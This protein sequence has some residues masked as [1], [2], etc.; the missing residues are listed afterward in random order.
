MNTH[1][2]AALLVILAPT[3]VLA[4]SPPEASG[5]KDIKAYCL[6]FN[7]APPAA[8]GKPF[9]NPGTWAGADPAA[10]VAWYKAIGANV[11]QTFCVST[12]GYAWY[13][14]GFVPEQPGLK[15]D[16]LPEVVKLG[17][18]EGMLVMGYFCIASNPTLGRRTIP[19]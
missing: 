7:W 18:Q 5:I 4:Q 11:I 8:R 12:N 3:D 2:L 13:K 17:H 19:T 10:H 16:F 15:H 9:A 14:N 1:V 6:D